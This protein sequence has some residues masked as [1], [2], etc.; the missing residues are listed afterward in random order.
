MRTSRW[1]LLRMRNISNKI[2]RENQNTHFMFSNVFSKIVPFIRQFRKILVEPEAI[3][4]VTIRRICIACWI[5]K[6]TRT[7]IYTPTLPGT[8]THAR[9]YTRIRTH[10]NQC[11]ILIAFPLQQWFANAPQY[12]V[13]RTLPVCLSVLSY[14]LYVN[15]YADLL[16][17]WRKPTTCTKT[18]VV[19]R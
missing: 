12:Y 6:T 16:A 19:Y 13:I 7:R 15:R 10:T 1:I 3:N 18:L 11:T 14:H 4:D 17:L 8:H 9:T 5:V 2:C